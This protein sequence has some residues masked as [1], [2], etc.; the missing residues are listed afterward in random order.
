LRRAEYNACSLRY[1]RSLP[2]SNAVIL[3]L[4]RFKARKN[5]S[6]EAFKKWLCAIFGITKLEK[7]YPTSNALIRSVTSKYAKHRQMVIKRQTEERLKFEKLEYFPTVSVPSTTID[8]HCTCQELTEEITKL[9]REFKKQEEEKHKLEKR[10]KQHSTRN[11][12]KR[13]KRRD[14]KVLKLSKEVREKDLTISYLHNLIDETKKLL[15]T[16]VQK[17]ESYKRKW[18]YW[19]QKAKKSILLKEVM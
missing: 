3:E 2:V 11:I 7:E 12:N 6:W 13:I 18:Q 8:L 9:K 10:L 14:H 15:T 4:R 16:K 17:A 19:K 1:K 5:Y